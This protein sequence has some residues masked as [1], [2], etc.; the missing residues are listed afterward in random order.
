MLAK[1]MF[2]VKHSKKWVKNAYSSQFNAINRLQNLSLRR[3]TCFLGEMA[4]YITDVSRET[5]IVCLKM[6]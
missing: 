2:H 4:L 3:L 1:K 6:G 5:M